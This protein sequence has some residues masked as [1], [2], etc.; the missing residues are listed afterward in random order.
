MSSVVRPGH[1]CPVLLLRAQRQGSG[2]P[3]L[4]LPG[5]Q[6][7]FLCPLQGFQPKPFPGWPW[8]PTGKSFVLPQTEKELGASVWTGL[9]GGNRER[10]DTQGQEGGPRLRGGSPTGT[11]GNGVRGSLVA[12]EVPSVERGDATKAPTSAAASALPVSTPL[13]FLLLPPCPV[14]SD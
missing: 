8:V 3:V 11:L 5:S 12:R 4:V 6:K 7:N 1:S 14:Q 13:C 2:Q 9:G 10:H